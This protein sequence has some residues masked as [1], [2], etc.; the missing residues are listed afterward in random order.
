LSAARG[1]RKKGT[2]DYRNRSS[3]SRLHS[4][5]PVHR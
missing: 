3:Y 4:E 2:A 5:L 1:C